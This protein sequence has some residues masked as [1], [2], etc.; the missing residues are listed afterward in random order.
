MRDPTERLVGEHH[1][2]TEGVIGGVALPHGDLVRLAIAMGGELL[3]EGGK[4]QP[5]GPSA[6]HRDAHGASPADPFA[7]MALSMAAS[8]LAAMDLSTTGG[9]HGGHVGKIQWP[10]SRRHRR[11]RWYRARGRGQVRGRGR[12]CGRRRHEL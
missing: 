10:D 3:S 6:D 1:T 5:T 7:A 8:N 9:E 12:R 11:S 4:V 2:E